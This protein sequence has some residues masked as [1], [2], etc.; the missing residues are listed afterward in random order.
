M[1]GGVESEPGDQGIQLEPVTSGVICS[2][3]TAHARESA[4]YPDAIDAIFV[5]QALVPSA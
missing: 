2:N 4:L 1:A 5:V 3:G